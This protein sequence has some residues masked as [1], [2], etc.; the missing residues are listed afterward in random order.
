MK[1]LQSDKITKGKT[2][3]DKTNV[4]ELFNSYNIT[5]VEKTAGIPPEIE[6]PRT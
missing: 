4:I 1:T 6:G 3:T 5:T 2:V